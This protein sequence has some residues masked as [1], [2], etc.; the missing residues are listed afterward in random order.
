MTRMTEVLERKAAIS[1]VGS[2]KIGRNLNRAPLDLTFDAIYETLAHAGLTFDDIDGLATTPGVSQ[3]PGMSPV[4]LRDVKNGLG[5]KLNW[6]SS[7]V[8]GPSTMTTIMNAAMAVATGQARHVLCYRTATQDLAKRQAIMAAPRAA[9]TPASRWNGWQ[10]WAFP[11]NALSPA[12]SFAMIARYRMEKFGLTRDQLGAWAVNCRRNA[13]LNPTAV[14][15]APMTLDDYLSARMISD[16]LC[17]LDCDAPI[18][19]AIAVIV[20]A[21]DAAR[22][23]R[24]PP[25]RIEA[26]SGALYGRDSWDQYEDIAGMAAND[27]GAHLWSR[28][29]LKPSD[30]DVGNFYDG[31]SIQALVW[32]EA[33]GFCA[34][35]ESGAFIEGGQRIALEG[36]IPLNTGGGQL[37]GG[38]TH[39]FG[40]LKESCLQLWGQAGDRQV[41]NSPEVAL[42]AVGGGALAGCLLLTRP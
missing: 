37:S 4:P 21:V 9:D 26:M 6:F 35:G 24:N 41:S 22:D 29:D 20:S 1:G 13:R 34:R 14:F 18:D 27:A 28:T 40:L 8:E 36:E 3:S 11:F 2:S 23:L 42:T 31:F 10:M 17:L 16:P 38:R 7:M 12:N 33:L 25:L 32:L 5:L 30:V 15:R 19:S 39:G